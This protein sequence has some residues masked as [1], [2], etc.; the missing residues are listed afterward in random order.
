MTGAVGE[1]RK[2][3]R[4]PGAVQTIENALAVLEAFDTAGREYQLRELSEATGLS[5]STVH[6][7]LRTLIA[8]S[9]VAQSPTSGAYRLGVRLLRFANYLRSDSD[10]VRTARPRLE[11]LVQRCGET[12]MLAVL[13]GVTLIYLDTLEPSA[14]VRLARYPDAT[15]PPHGSSMGKVLLAHADEAV[16]DELLTQPLEAFTT[17]TIVDADAFK[18]ELARIRKQGFAKNTG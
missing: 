16:V 3:R 1:V 6:R 5:K 8:H 17:A 11:E 12:V 10:L 18:K 7:V 4:E 13:D 2:P 15:S 14:L 9:Y